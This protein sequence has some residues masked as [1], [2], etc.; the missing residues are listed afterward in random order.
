MRKRTESKKEQQN[1]YRKP[2]EAISG[3]ETKLQQAF[4]LY[5]EGKTQ[6]AEKICQ[7]VLANYPLNAEY[8]H[9]TVKYSRNIIYN[10]C[11]EN[12]F[13]RIF[14]NTLKVDLAKGN[15]SCVSKE[16]FLVKSLYLL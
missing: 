11:D 8:K 3:V 7:Q 14:E 13:M 5:Q 1:F 9:P 6:Q 10:Y 15:K 12:F 4:S 2:L 16:R